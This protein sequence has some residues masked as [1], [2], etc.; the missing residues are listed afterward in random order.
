M[1][2]VILVGLGEMARDAVINLGVENIAYAYDNYLKEEIKIWEDIPVLCFDELLEKAK[3]YRIIITPKGGE[4][5]FELCKQFQDL[6]LNYE[7]YHVNN[8]IP[9]GFVHIFGRF[10]E[11][12]YQFNCMETGLGDWA[13]SRADQLREMFR[14]VFERF[15]KDFLDL[16]IDIWCYLGDDPTTAYQDAIGAGLKHICCYATTDALRDV[17]IPM[18]DYNSFISENDTG[19]GWYPE[20][21]TFND[22][23]LVSARH[24]VD[25]RAF[26]VGNLKNNRLRTE[27]YWL[28]KKYPEYLDIY[29]KST[30][31][32]GRDGRNKYIPPEDFTK[33]KYLIDV[34]GVSWADRTKKLLQLGRPVLLVDR[35]EK[36]WYWDDLVPMKQYVPIRADFSD[37]IQKIIF[38]NENPKVYE[39]IVRNARMF[40]D[41]HFSPEKTLSYMRSLI[42]KYGSGLSSK[43][44][45]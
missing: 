39:E 21:L 30:P 38:L 3:D 27:L 13:F 37:L 28:G 2:K 40:S 32:Q 10:P 44:N 16:D 42:L 1:K 25:E 12:R 41:E 4:A 11:I 24:Y 20:H 17:I 36:E 8:D 6:H 5:R 43:N 23:K 7:L 14:A 22:Y 35:F 26:W 33:Y 18:P 45:I 34:P 9:S 19:R 15:T 31:H 29:S